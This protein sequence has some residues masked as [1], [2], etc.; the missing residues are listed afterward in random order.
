MSSSADKQGAASADVERAKQIIR[1]ESAA[2]EEIRTLAES[3]KDERYFTY[4][5]QLFALALKHPETRR[6]NEAQRLKLVQRQALCTYRDPDLPSESR[7]SSALALLESADLMEKQPSSL[8]EKQPSSETLGLAGAIY[9]YQWKLTGRRRD[10]ERSAGYYG[11]GAA[12]EVTDDKG[13]TAINAA[14]V[15]DL[16]TQQE[17]D[18]A[19]TEALRHAR[20]ARAI[21]ERIISQLPPFADKRGNAEI[22]N[23]WWFLATLAEACFGLGRFSEAPARRT[24]SCSKA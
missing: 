24:G 1:G 20:E 8:M 3:L 13:Y 11:A 18:D 6:L 12:R 15:L 22:K 7:F 17:R 19:P 2:L 14:F 5:R 16:L 9:K 21:R 10:L 23:Q 4:A